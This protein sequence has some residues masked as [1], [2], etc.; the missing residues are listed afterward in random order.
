MPYPLTANAQAK[1]NRRDDVSIT[2][3]AEI[4]TGEN[5]LRYSEYPTFD[6]M[7][8]LR[9]SAS[10]F[11][12]L[13]SAGQ[14]GS[15]TINICDED[16]MLKDLI[17]TTN[18]IG[19][20]VEIFVVF[21]DLTWADRVL[22]FS[23]KVETPFRWNENTRIVTL[24]C[25]PESLEG[26]IPAPIVF[27]DMP[28]VKV[29]DPLDGLK[30]IS[31]LYAQSK[32]KRDR[33][34]A[35]IVTYNQVFSVDRE[36]P[37]EMLGEFYT[38]LVGKILVNGTF[39]TLNQFTCASTNISFALPNFLG[40]KKD[41]V[42]F[43]NTSIAFLGPVDTSNPGLE[44]GLNGKYIRMKIDI[45]YNVWR[46]NP[47]AYEET[48]G[49]MYGN[50]EGSGMTPPEK[51]P[52]MPTEII[53][54]IFDQSIFLVNEFTK[55]DY[56]LQTDERHDYYEYI[57]KC[58]SHDVG[59]G[60]IAFDK[61]PTTMMGE[62]ILITPDNCQIIGVYGEYPLKVKGNMYNE[63]AEYWT[64]GDSAKITFIGLGT[65]HLVSVIPAD[66]VVNVF[67]SEM[68]IKRD[69]EYTEVLTPELKIYV[70][71][72]GSIWCSIKSSVGPNIIDIIK[73]II[74]NYT[75]LT[76][77]TS[78]Y[79]TLHALHEDFPV[80]FYYEEEVTVA[81]CLKDICYQACLE[82]T[83]YSKTFKLEDAT[84]RNALSSLLSLD[85]SNTEIGSIMWETS[86]SKN[87]STSLIGTWS[88]T[89][90]PGHIEEEYK[91]ENNVDV[92]EERIKTI[93]FPIYHAE[94]S[95]ERAIT[96]YLD[97]LSNV[98]EYVSFRCFLNA[99]NMYP[100]RTQIDMVGLSMQYHIVQQSS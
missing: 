75:T 77:D 40:R 12:L 9:L 59:N 90:Y 80:G 53:E 67:D 35:N 42:D 36:V 89:E 29:V 47:S 27:G 3:V 84:K 56:N 76:F 62:P 32:G 13:N 83:I 44:A 78:N 65:N 33:R 93:D 61:P 94:G 60:K 48:G 23:G 21:N 81:D 71:E 96:W 82:Y 41:D 37:E 69:D 1:I 66:D 46:F 26:K 28:G 5:T 4:T 8:G 7:K 100:Y 10:I 74:E 39:T 68:N 51:R 16:G 30:A 97:L 64:T 15:M 17:T 57:C 11:E 6:A 24:T 49:T 63:Y 79:A 20:K 34:T 85:H 88:K 72:I 95:V 19:E 2:V 22:V 54:P 70:G 91:A 38:L 50:L 86:N 43:D 87:L 52:E 31:H 55:S 18:L 99:M 25:L 58:T 98:W 73:F 92:F 45:K 14:T